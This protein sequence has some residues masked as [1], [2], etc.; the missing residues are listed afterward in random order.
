MYSP[1]TGR[2]LTKDSWP[3]DYN[4]PLSLNRWNYVEGNPVNRLDPTGH[5]STFSDQGVNERDLTWWLSQEL[6]ANA[7]SSYTQKIKTLWNSND[8]FAKKRGL[9]AFANLVKDRAKWDFKH[10]IRDEMGQSV[11]LFDNN[12]DG[13]GNAGGSGWWYEY[14]VPGNIHFGFVGRA[15]GIPGWLLHLGAG[16]AEVTDPS[17]LKRE[18]FGY[19]ME[20]CCPCPG[21]AAGETCRQYLCP[22]VNWMWIGTGFDEP[23]D[24]NAVETGIQLFDTYGTNISYSQFTQGLTSRG[25]SLDHSG[26]KPDWIWSNPQG[27]WPYTVGRFNGSREAEYEPTIQGL[28]K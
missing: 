27:G 13:L 16:K 12:Y 2:F 26:V 7:N 25:Q 9:D 5:M 10:K 1:G 3:G 4:R 21:G 15:A 17:H 18:I 23:R 28:L 20:D 11:V 6:T 24:F 8:L 19:K 22:Y 14:S